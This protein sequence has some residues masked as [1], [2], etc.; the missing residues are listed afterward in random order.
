[1]RIS[2]LISSIHGESAVSTVTEEIYNLPSHNFEIVVCSPFEI[3]DSRVKWVKD[4]KANGSVY[5]YNTAYKASN[6]DCLVAVTDDHHVPKNFLETID[7]LESEIVNKLKLKIANLTFGM[8]GPGKIYYIKN[9]GTKQPAKNILWPLN[10]IFPPN[11]PNGRPFNVFHFPVLMR[12]SIEKYMG[13][14][15]FNELFKHHY[16]DSWLGFYEELINGERP[17]EELGPK[18]VFFE[19]IPSINS[20]KSNSNFDAEDKAT[21]LKLVEKSDSKDLQYNTNFK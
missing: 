1:M 7:F 17:S 4:D 16:P 15:I 12:E 18:N 21:F 19:A 10:Q 5:S 6:G 2:Y 14:V 8:G 13:N 9:D 20:Q 11:F 3:K